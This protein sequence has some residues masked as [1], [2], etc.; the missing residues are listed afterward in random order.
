MPMIAFLVQY[1]CD[2][3]RLLYELLYGKTN[4]TIYVPSKDLDQNGHLHS[5]IRVIP[6][7]SMTKAFWSDLRDHWMQSLNNCFCH[8]K[9]HI[10]L[11]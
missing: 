7:H 6:I 1:T 9:G 5:L 3:K 8:K 11:C 4:E 10:F 2:W